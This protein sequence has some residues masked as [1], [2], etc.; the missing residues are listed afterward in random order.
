MAS[1]T[2]HDRQPDSCHENP[3]RS[4]PYPTTAGTRRSDSM[5]GR[6][7]S[8]AGHILTGTFL[9]RG[10]LEGRVEE[11]VPDKNTPIVTH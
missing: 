3:Q 7:T 11:L 5:L 4:A 6:E 2:R 1:L 8:D 9:P 10:R